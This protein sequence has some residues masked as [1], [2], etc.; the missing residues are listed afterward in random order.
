MVLRIVA[1]TVSAILPSNYYGHVFLAILAMVV[2][3]TFTQ[4]RS[5]TRERDLHARVILVTVGAIAQHTTLV[6]K[7]SRRALFRV[8]SPLLD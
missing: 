8:V 1:T 2:I 7:H 6:A 5:T 4:G 3:R